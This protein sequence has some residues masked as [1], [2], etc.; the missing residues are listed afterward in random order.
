MNDDCAERNQLHTMRA[1]L[2]SWIACVAMASAAVA[3]RSAQTGVQAGDAALQRETSSFRITF[4]ARQP[5]LSAL[6]VDSLKHG[7]FPPSPLD[8]PGSPGSPAAQYTVQVKG[9]WV[10]YAPVSD[11]GH[12]VWEMRCDGNALRMRSLFS[13]KGT[14]QDLTLRFNPDVTHAT[15]LGRVTPAGDVELPAVLHLPGMGSLRVYAKGNDA[16]ALHYDARRTGTALW[17]LPFPRPRLNTNRSNIHSKPL[18]SFRQFPAWQQTIP[19]RRLPARLAGHFS[20]ACGMARAG[21]PCGQR[22]RR[23]HRI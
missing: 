8:D 12:P 5:G 2:R 14:A 1:K 21:Q 11:A 23:L 16:A 20:A 17:R 9:G 7:S 4:D 13:P 10:R 6:S 19:V 18:R 22:C 3:A 15:L